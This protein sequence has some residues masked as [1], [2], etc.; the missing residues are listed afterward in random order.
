MGRYEVN[1][2]SFRLIQAFHPFIH[3]SSIHSGTLEDNEKIRVAIVFLKVTKL[4]FYYRPI[5]E[6]IIGGGTLG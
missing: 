3:P 1:I 4:L 5:D 6:V 2:S